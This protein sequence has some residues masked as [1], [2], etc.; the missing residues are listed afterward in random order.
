[1]LDL[2]TP[3][4]IFFLI[5]SVILVAAGA[6][7]PQEIQ[8]GSESINLDVIWGVV[9]GVFG[10]FMLSLRLMTKSKIE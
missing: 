8:V 9:M 1:M 6:I 3:I 2:R 10:A 5:N 7:Q 4:G